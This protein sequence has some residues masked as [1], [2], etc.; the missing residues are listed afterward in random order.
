MKICGWKDLK[1]MQYYIRLAGVDER[2]ATDSLRL[3][4][5]DAEVMG[6]VVNMFNFKP[7]EPKK[8]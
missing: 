6:E 7:G 3:L 1:T 8:E 5:S 4:S 2:G